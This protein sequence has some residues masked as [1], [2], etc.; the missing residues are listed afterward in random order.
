MAWTVVHPSARV[1]WPDMIKM[2]RSRTTGIPDLAGKVAVVTGGASGIGRGIA[3]QLVAHGMKVV[4]AD[5]EQGALDRSAAEIGAVG[6]RTDVA[7]FD[8]VLALADEV[9]RQFGGLHLLCNNAGVASMARVAD[10]AL[11]DWAWLLGVNLWGVIHGVKAFLPMLKAN[12]EGGHV[13][14]TAS[15]AG[16]HVT[17]GMG[18]YSVSKFAV[19]ALS[20]TLALELE[21]GGSGVGVTILCP[22]PVSTKLGSS[23]RNRPTPLAGSALV[24]CD[25]EAMAEGGGLRWVEPDYAGAVTVRAIRRGDLYAFTHPEMASLVRERH[26]NIAAAFDGAAVEVGGS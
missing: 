5:I 21:E 4:I 7:S 14:N 18:G 6:I 12:A 17:S 10:M 20:E 15:M 24:D 1:S 16:L 13:V 19:V 3:A 11:S 26:K 23:Q 8:S 9:Q 2:A 22:G 25:L